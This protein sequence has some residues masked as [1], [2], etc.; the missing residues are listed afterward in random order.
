VRIPRQGGVQNLVFSTTF[1]PH[2]NKREIG[3][4]SN[5]QYHVADSELLVPLN[6]WMKFYTDQHTNAGEREAAGNDCVPVS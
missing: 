2:N 4:L 5:L 1:N 3:G 6:D